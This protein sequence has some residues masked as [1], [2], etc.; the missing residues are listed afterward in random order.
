L[1]FLFLRLSY[2]AIPGITAFEIFLICCG[3]VSGIFE[4][5]F[6]KALIPLIEAIAFPG[7]YRHIHKRGLVALE[8]DR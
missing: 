4:N 1:F 2:L 3:A 5:R 8:I 6:A 7:F